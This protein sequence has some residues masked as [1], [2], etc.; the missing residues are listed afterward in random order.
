M[1][2]VDVKELFNDAYERYLKK[3]EDRNRMIEQMP[4]KQRLNLILNSIF[5]N[6]GEQDG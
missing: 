3:V 2:R 6:E 1:N 5:R 4:L